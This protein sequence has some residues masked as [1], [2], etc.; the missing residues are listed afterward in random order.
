[1]PLGASLLPSAF[2]VIYANIFRVYRK[3]QKERIHILMVLL[4]S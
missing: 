3:E 4:V 2:A 1:M